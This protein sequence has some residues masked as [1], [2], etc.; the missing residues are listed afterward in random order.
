MTYPTTGPPLITTGAEVTLVKP[1]ELN[2][3]SW[4]LLQQTAA[5]LGLTLQR[6]DPPGK[7]ALQLEF[8]ETLAPR[9]E[10]AGTT[11]FE[12]TVSPTLSLHPLAGSHVLVL[13]ARREVRNV[14]REA[15]RPLSLMV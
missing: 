12:E 4:R 10:P 3:M 6:S 9:V 15:L 11:D 14:V 5:V 13:A 1:A 7:T 8:P 2:T